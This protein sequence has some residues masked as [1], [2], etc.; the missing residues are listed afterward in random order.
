MDPPWDA[1]SWNEEAGVADGGDTWASWVQGF[2][3]VY[4]VHCHNSKDPTGR[5]FNFLDIVKTNAS[6]IRCGIFPADGGTRDSAWSCPPG[7]PPP[8]QFPLPTSTP[9]PTDDER[10]RIIAWIDAGCP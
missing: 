10:F 1:S 9:Q 4:C 8:A 3:E 6:T 7:F 2:V 5:D